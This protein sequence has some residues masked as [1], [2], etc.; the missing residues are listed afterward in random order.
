MS[1][2]AAADNPVAPESPTLRRA[3]A[4]DAAEE[5]GRVE[6]AIETA[7]RT[8]AQARYPPECLPARN[9]LPL[10]LP[11]RPRGGDPAAPQRGRTL[12]PTERAEQQTPLPRVLPRDPPGE[13][14]ITRRGAPPRQV[15]V[16]TEV[17]GYD[18]SVDYGVTPNPLFVEF[19]RK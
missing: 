15:E 18:P 1:T 9:H 4:A 12:P 7:D 19:H 17:E 3:L 10:P 8:A 16:L 13:E 5:R 14:N 2:A 6:S 11:R